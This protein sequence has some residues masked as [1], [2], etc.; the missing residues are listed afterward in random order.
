MPSDADITHLSEEQFT[1]FYLL[2]L[3]QARGYQDVEYYHGGQTE[4]GKDVTMWRYDP[5]QIRENYAVVVKAGDIT[6]SASGSGSANTVQFQVQQCFKVPFVDKKTAAPQDT[7]K[8]FIV[9]SGEIKNNARTTIKETLD[10]FSRYIRFF[11]GAEILSQFRRFCPEKS[12]VEDF[13][14]TSVALQKQLKGVQLT[15]EIAAGVRQL[16]FRRVAGDAE[17]EKWIMSLGIDLD[18]VN[19]EMNSKL[20]AFNEE[21]GSIVLS[22]GTFYI[23]KFPEVLILLGVRPEQLGDFVL[24]QIPKELGNFTLE[25]VDNED[26]SVLSLR[27]QIWIVSSGSNRVRLENRGDASAFRILIETD[28]ESQRITATFSVSLLGYNSYSAFRAVQFLDALSRAGHLRLFS[29]DTG[30]VLVDGPTDKSAPKVRQLDLKLLEKLAHVQQKTGQQIMI[31]REILA[32]DISDIESAYVAVTSGRLYFEEGPITMNAKPDFTLDPDVPGWD[33]VVIEPSIEER[34]ITVLDNK[35][36]LGE[37]EIVATKG[38][39]K[40]EQDGKVIKLFPSP[41]EPFYLNFVRYS[42]K[43]E[44]PDLGG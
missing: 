23:A 4:K 33:S 40:V 30:L 9:A 24:T 28:R 20:K 5:E 15:S 12:A 44:K 26:K 22:K 11:D 7:H 14:K 6:G 41:G 1:R 31:N 38:I 10:A 32:S 13:L 21:G 17:S 37:T 42:G 27:T 39:P 2:P 3:Y 36:D 34:A 19:A 18:A 35:I 43:S 25:F 16:I 8:C 29:D